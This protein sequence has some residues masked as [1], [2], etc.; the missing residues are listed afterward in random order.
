MKE[1]SHSKIIENNK[2]GRSKEEIDKEHQE[3]YEGK[4][5]HGQL[6]I[7][8]EEVRSKRSWD[9]LKKG[10]LKK[11][12]ESTIVAAQELVL[13]TRNVN[14]VYGENFQS[15]CRACG[16]ADETVAHIVSECYNYRRRSTSK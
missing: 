3:K 2:Y 15:I 13:G 14:V 11:E 7:A 1:L 8:T 12:T 10:Y 6:I 4:P 9:W 5:L 16:A